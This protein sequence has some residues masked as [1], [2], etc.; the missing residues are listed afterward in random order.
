MS[1]SDENHL[2]DGRPREW[3]GDG[4][5][6][7]CL[8]PECGECCSG[9]HGP[10]AVW[11]DPAEMQAIAEALRM[12]FETFTSKFVRLVDG[13]YSL[14]EKPNFDC[15]FYEAGKGCTVYNARPRQCR[16]FPFWGRI[17][18]S[19]RSWEE[20]GRCCPGINEPGAVVP[21]EEIRNYLA[22]KAGEEGRQAKGGQAGR[23]QP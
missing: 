17:L 20:S 15:A 13:R 12:P 23:S 8:G 21:A 19:R 5:E 18:R 6:F 2:H 9:K 16:T 14:V 22:G 11:V 4:V 7:R 1:S 10:G 3:Y